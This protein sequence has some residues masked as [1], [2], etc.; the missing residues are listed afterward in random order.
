MKVVEIYS[1]R[2]LKDHEDGESIKKCYRLRAYGIKLWTEVPR[3]SL[4]E[5]VNMVIFLTVPEAPWCPPANDRCR[6]PP[7][8]SGAT[9]FLGTSQV[10]NLLGSKVRAAVI[11][12]ASLSNRNKN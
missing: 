10:R 7:L 8:I 4:F 12:S 9:I 5:L 2:Y 6:V 3:K 11:S 1:Q